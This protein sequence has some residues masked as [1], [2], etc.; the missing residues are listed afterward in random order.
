MMY[1][2]VCVMM[3][4][5]VCVMMYMCV[6]VMMY[7]CVCVMMYVSVCVMMYVSVCVMTVLLKYHTF[8]SVQLSLTLYTLTSVFIFSIL[9]SVHLL[10][11]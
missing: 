9:F 1:V 6:C 3:Y 5:C 7:V 8:F 2:C 11:Y 10:R 4:V